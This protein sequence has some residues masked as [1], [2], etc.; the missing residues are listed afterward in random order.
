M[1]GGRKKSIRSWLRRNTVFLIIVLVAVATIVSLS[2]LISDISENRAYDRYMETAR[3]SILTGDYDG[4][5]SF[6]R[7]AASID[8]T[9]DCLLLMA[10]CYESQGNYDKAILALRSMSSTSSAVTTK[11][12]SI[13][14]TK[15]QA[16]SAGKVIIAGEAFDVS[17]TSLALD[18]RG[19]GNDIM[20]E[21]S[22][23]YALSALSLAGNCISDVQPVSNL[24]GLT[25]L[26]LN[27]N[28][29][30]DISS[31]ASLS[32]LRTLYLDDNPVTDF[33][34]LFYLQSLTSLSIKGVDITQD[35]LKTLS[36]ALPNCAINGAGV[37]GVQSDSASQ[38][39]A[40]G[41]MTFDS[42]VRE[43]DLSYR[44]ITDISALSGCSR[45][46]KLNLSGNAVGDISPLMDIPSLSSL[47]ISSN[48]VTDLRPL[49]GISSLKYLYASNNNI[50]STVS[51][52]S[53]TALTELD[54]S[55][56]PISDFSGI[57]KLKNLM[58]LDLSGTGMR[59]TDIQFFS[60]LSRLVSLNVENNP[61][62]TGE[63]VTQLKSM[64]PSCSL[65]HSGLVFSI[66]ASGNTVDSNTTS[67]DMTGQGID[68]LSFLSKLTNL[69]SARLAANNLTNIYS[70]QYTE[71][72]RTLTYLDL[73]S[74]YISDITPVSG[75]RNLVTLNLSDN[76]ITNVTPLY[77]MDSLRELYLGGNPLNDGQIRELNAYLPQCTIVFR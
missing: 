62:L 21:I 2:V 54:L 68:D 27:G 50:F 33:S 25:S 13:E 56:N 63:A 65:K 67:I 31:L 44:G 58:K 7:K 46:T 5:L 14:A 72:W 51:L 59:P 3:E 23:M 76:L 6:L 40:L 15:Q 45:L 26:N 19:L 53:N 12:A 11:I 1:S 35:E 22:R 24:H 75:L 66:E 8:A 71:S 61:A 43:L 49:M 16:E 10:Q 39:I 4:A 9:D 64:I 57:R 36:A 74:N 32:G 30:S 17:E 37:S 47:N 73:S 41:G 69:Q 52:G 29:V 70:F 42:D 48:S 20:L 18:N 60:Y 38:Y 34:P 55:G 77:G 28:Q